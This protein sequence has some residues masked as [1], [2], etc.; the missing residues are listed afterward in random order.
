MQGY[1]IE[2][3]HRIYDDSEGVCLEVRPDPDTGTAMMLHAPTEN[4]KKWFGDISL[5]LE[6][7]Q[8]EKL[9]KCLM[10]Q[11]EAQRQTST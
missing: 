7:E 9:A 6:L 10:M 11:V 8:A 2:I 1:S 5:T 3:S 4:D